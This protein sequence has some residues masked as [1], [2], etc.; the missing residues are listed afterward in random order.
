MNH[1][2]Q[3][4]KNGKVVG[5]FTAAQLRQFRDRG[6]LQST[7]KVRPEG[8]QEWQTLAEVEAAL[9]A[10]PPTPTGPSPTGGRPRLGPRPTGAP[11][12]QRPP[13]PPAPPEELEPFEGAAKGP[14]TLEL[15]I[16]PDVVP[17]SRAVLQ[18]A[19]YLSRIGA[20]VLDIFFSFFVAAIPTVIVTIVLFAVLVGGPIRPNDTVDVRAQKE[21]LAILV[22]VLSQLF[23]ALLVMLYYVL[24]DASER[25]GTWG[26]QIVGIK[27]ADLQGRRISHG[28]AF[29]RY[30]AKILSGCSCGI[31][32]LMPLFTERK[33]TL[34]DLISGCL[35]LKK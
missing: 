21:S 26:K 14:P 4:F 6:Q 10:P 33:Q 16:S 34:H 13:T 12:V 24:F 18:Y 17:T 19:D 9:S 27:V 25:Q 30:V 35:A 29:G 3:V 1:R 2:W 5:P 20:A 31:G 8:Q 22:S 15:S 23:F 32:F 7:D 11:P 28:R